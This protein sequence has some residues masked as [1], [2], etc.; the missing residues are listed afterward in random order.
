M[1]PG[2]L[3]VACLWNGLGP[4]FG[5]GPARGHVDRRV[6]L[7]TFIAWTVLVF[8]EVGLSHPFAAK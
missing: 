7:G 6:A 1:I 2:R 3:W 8:L 4:H 5:L